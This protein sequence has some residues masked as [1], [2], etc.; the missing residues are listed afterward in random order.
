M[1][2]RGASLT[3]WWVKKVGLVLFNRWAGAGK[4]RGNNDGDIRINFSMTSANAYAEK[5]FPISAF[6]SMPTD[7]AG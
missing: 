7:P 4:V 6:K 1:T 5:K 2:S 3:K